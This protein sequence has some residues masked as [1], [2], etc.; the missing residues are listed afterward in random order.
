MKAM[1]KRFSGSDVERIATGVQT[2]LVERLCPKLE[3]P[4][5]CFMYQDDW[6]VDEN[7][8][9]IAQHQDR[10]GKVAGEFTVDKIEKIWVP[11]YSKY[12]KRWDIS[13]VT[14]YDTPKDIS[15]FRHWSENH[16]GT[17]LVKT[18]PNWSYVEVDR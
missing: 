10:V 14:M 6:L 15:E 5:V 8:D 7:L 1:L 3:I 4:F 18:P 9:F 17:K 2:H 13:S 12:V 11:T 16:D